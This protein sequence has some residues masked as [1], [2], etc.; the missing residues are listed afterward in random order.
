MGKLLTN[1]QFRRI[2]DEIALSSMME[3]LQ[4][5]QTEAQLLYSQYHTLRHELQETK[6]RNKIDALNFALYMKSSGEYGDKG[7]IAW[8]WQAAAAQV[9]DILRDSRYQNQSILGS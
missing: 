9:N 2:R 3:R 7:G 8:Q 4:K 6:D 5:L 1:K